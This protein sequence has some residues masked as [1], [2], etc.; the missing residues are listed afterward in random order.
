MLRPPWKTNPA[1]PTWCLPI[2]RARTRRRPN[3]KPRKV[4]IR[5]QHRSQRKRGPHG[6]RF[7]F[8]HGARVVLPPRT[9]GKWRVRLRDL[10]SGNILFQSENQGAFVSSSKR[11]YVRIG[12]AVWNVGD[13]GTATEVISHGYDARDREI[14][15]QLPVGTIGDTIGWFPCVARFAREHGACAICVMAGNLVLLLRG[16]YPDLWL[17]THEEG[18]S[19]EIPERVYASVGVGAGRHGLCGGV[20]LANV[21]G[22]GI[23]VTWAATNK[24][25]GAWLPDIP[26]RR[27][28]GHRRA[29]PSL[30]RD[31]LPGGMGCALRGAPRALTLPM[32]PV[33][34]TL[35]VIGL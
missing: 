22:A 5:L 9:E 12:V 18:E 24:A 15:I 31:G 2:P 35:K 26:D 13:T 4:R 34:V 16:T 11:Y 10:D 30:S 1:H 6:V 20:D 19:E 14:L 32:V 25:S 17:V 28:S 33:G 7:D 21:G 29:L 23:V 8:D 27:S 3:R